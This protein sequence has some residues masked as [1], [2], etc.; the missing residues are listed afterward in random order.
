MNFNNQQL[1]LYNQSKELIAYQNS[2]AVPLGIQNTKEFPTKADKILS[3]QLNQILALGLI[4]F[5]ETLNQL[6]EITDKLT[7]LSIEQNSKSTDLSRNLDKIQDQNKRIIQNQEITP[8]TSGSNQ[9]LEVHLQKIER[10]ISLIL[11]DIPIQNTE[12]VKQEIQ[13]LKN[14]LERSQNTI[15]SDTILLLK[16]AV[17]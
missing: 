4:G 2:D 5:S 16:E 14:R 7:N 6:R 12:E 1:I 13:D 11:K 8:S 9:N 10:E 3:T 17:N 15:K